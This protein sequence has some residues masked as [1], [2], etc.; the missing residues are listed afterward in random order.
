LGYCED[1]TKGKDFV[2]GFAVTVGYKLV[3]SFADGN[4]SKPGVSEIG[5]PCKDSKNNFFM[6][7]YRGWQIQQYWS[8]WDNGCINR[9]GRV[10]LKRFLTA[11]GVDFQ[12]YGLRSLGSS[13][14][15]VDFKSSTMR[16]PPF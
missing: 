12:H 2:S 3:E 15:N 5:D 11:I 8:D 10:S 14:I 16:S 4:G 9:D 6:F 1:D 13:V 7:T